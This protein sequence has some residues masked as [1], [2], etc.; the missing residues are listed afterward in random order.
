MSSDMTSYYCLNCDTRHGLGSDDTLF[1][2]NANYSSGEESIDIVART[3][4]WRVAHHQIYAILNA[5][6][7][8]EEGEQTPHVSRRRNTE[9]S[10]SNDDNDYT[11]AEEEWVA[12]RAAILNNTGLPSGNSVGTL[13]AYRSILE[14]N[15]GRLSNEQANLDRRWIVA[16]Q[17]S[18]C[19]R[20]SHAGASWSNQGSGR[21]RPS[22]P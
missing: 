20:A 9:N 18:E 3:T 7:G 14:R 21:Y 15:R 1:I 4:T 17:S 11:I 6:D 19:R 12:A 2:C 16:G 5:A 10:A 13:N 22:M 8:G